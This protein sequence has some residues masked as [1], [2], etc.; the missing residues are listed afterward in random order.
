MRVVVALSSELA[1]SSLLTQRSRQG[2]LTK[3]CTH[4]WAISFPGASEDPNPNANDSRERSAQPLKQ[5]IVALAL[6][7]SVIAIIAVRP[8][9]DAMRV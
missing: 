1:R 3:P 9:Y 7:N 8:A 4:H 5:P 6:Q 2:C